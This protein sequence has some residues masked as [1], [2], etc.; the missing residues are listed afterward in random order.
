MKL[1]VPLL[2]SLVA[3][4][5]KSPPPPPP[6]A[7]EPPQKVAA[8][9]PV[10]DTSEPEEGVTIVNARGHMEKEA[11]EAGLQPHQQDM[12]DCY[13]KKVGRRRWLGGHVK[14]HWDIKKDGTV[15]KVVLSSE[16]DLG[17]WPIEKCLI[18]IAKVASFDKP[19]GGDADFDIPLQFDAKQSVL[20]WD[21]DASL[22]AVGGQ[23]V[24]LEACAKHE[25]SKK[26]VEHV[27]VPE[28]VT[29]TMYV[30][31]HGKAQSVG[32]SSDK[33]EIHEKWAECAEKA[34]LAWR[35]PDPKG[36]IAKL[37]IRYRGR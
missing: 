16:S 3:C 22:R 36:V 17:S 23:L 30:G 13:L 20:P 28:D 10:E 26:E 19:V 24:K 35:L 5:G 1:A 21:E 11:I 14:I 2:M 31:P 29:I 9:V 18:E 37:A 15:S 4:G 32:F 25:K 27:P 33:S 6:K 7:A 8:R 12:M 34:A